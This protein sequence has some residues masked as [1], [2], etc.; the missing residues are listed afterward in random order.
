MKTY[1][2]LNKHTHKY[3]IV[4][5]CISYEIKEIQVMI[6]PFTDLNNYKIV[7]NFSDGRT[8]TYPMDSFELYEL[9]EL[10][11]LKKAFRSC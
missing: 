6:A 11:I 7:V 3:E 2:I 8:A 9:V 10:E 4:H 1:L 5:N